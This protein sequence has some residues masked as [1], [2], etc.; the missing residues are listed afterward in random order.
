MMR[1]G[2]APSEFLAALALRHADAIVERN[3]RI[4]RENLERLDCFFESRGDLFG[5][6]RPRAGSI[7]FPA[8]LQGSVRRVLC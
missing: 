3:L 5:W 1:T 8:L 7:A 2:S 6:Y 4:I